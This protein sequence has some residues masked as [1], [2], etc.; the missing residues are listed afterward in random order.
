MCSVCGLENPVSMKVKF[1]NLE[2]GEVVGLFTPQELHQ[3]YPGKLHGGFAASILDELIGRAINSRG[4]EEIWLVTIELK[5]KFNVQI[6]KQIV[7]VKAV[8][9]RY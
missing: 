7:A 9:R 4:G 1:Y 6:S 3:G 8:S 2:N 5:I